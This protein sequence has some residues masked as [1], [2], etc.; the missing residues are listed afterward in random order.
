MWLK[1]SL[2]VASA[3]FFPLLIGATSP[4][5]VHTLRDITTTAIRPILETQD[6]V[7]T[8]IK[9]QVRSVVEWP[10]LLKRNRELEEQ[11][12]SVNAELINVREL[13][14]ENKRLQSLL[15]L[16]QGSE[17]KTVAARV[18]GRDPSHWSLFIMLNRGTKDGVHEDVPLLS[19]EG[20]VGKVVSA[21]PDSSRAILLTDSQSRVSVF[22]QRTRD[23]G[24]I[25]GTGSPLL[26]MTFLDRGADIQVGDTIVS[27]GVGE[28]YPKGIPI[29]R[30]QLVAEDEN[31][32]G[33]SA[34]VKP[35]VSFAKLEEIL[36]VLSPSN[37]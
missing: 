33:L 12:A 2:L 27:S 7:A 21:G 18:I 37:G 23:V 3:V 14:E 26:K 25:E 4:N 8:V 13:K 24:L 17:F 34:V 19:A 5:F 9:T 35:F 36:C 15:A 20:L 22:N 32:L 10:K 1:R 11:L 16:K 6:Q 29:G 30:V 28:V 31:R